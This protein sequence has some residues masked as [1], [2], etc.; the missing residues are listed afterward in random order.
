MLVSVDT[1][2]F[3]CL[4]EKKKKSSIKLTNAKWGNGD[5]PVD[6]HPVWYHCVTNL[7]ASLVE[8]DASSVQFL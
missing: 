4:P 2:V 3:F 1:W 7:D 6:R 8:K 5:F